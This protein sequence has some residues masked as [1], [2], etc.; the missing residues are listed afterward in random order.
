MQPRIHIGSAVITRL[1]FWP[2]K[3]KD[4][5]ITLVTR[6]SRATLATMSSGWW[7]RAGDG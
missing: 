7:D 2:P 4:L 6:M 5:D 3:P 1:V